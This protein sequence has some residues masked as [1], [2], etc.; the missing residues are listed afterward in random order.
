MQPVIAFVNDDKDSSILQDLFPAVRMARVTPSSPL[1]LSQ[2]DNTGRM[3]WVDPMI[4]GY[5]LVLKGAGTLAK[6][7][8]K[9]RAS[10][11]KDCG[12]DGAEALS[13]DGSS[14]LATLAREALNKCTQHLKP[15]WI[16]VPQLPVVSGPSRNK[17]NRSLAKA[18]G[19]W[20]SS[21]GYSAKLVLP[22]VFTHQSQLKNRTN[23]KPKIATARKCYE[24][25]GAS[26]VW[27]VDASLEDQK[28]T[29][30]FPKR[31][32]ALVDFHRDLRQAFPD[33][34]IVAGPYWG[35]NLV[36]WS[37][38]LCD[39]PAI[40]LGRG[41]R[42]SVSSTFLRAGNARIAITPLLRWAIV[43][44][45][46]RRWLDEVLK[47]LSAQD[48]AYGE[49]SVLRK[50]LQAYTVKGAAARQVA[51]FY[52]QWLDRLSASAPAGRALALYQEFSSAFVLGRQLP[53]MPKA[54]RTARRPERVA[55][56]LML[57]CL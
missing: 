16:T 20:R 25:S 15:K 54:E 53:T 11:E 8:P 5:D 29:G 21:S 56:Q 10:L 31:F 3:L 4:D 48:P 27:A 9:C 1:L 2:L 32:G 47:S 42:Y 45:T 35:M 28:G 38:Q 55:E 26:V 43:S 57:H 33:A 52:S 24:D 40:S 49:L 19:D 18:T 13:G 36:L 7:W 17:V 12:V 44:P 51:G 6:S 50:R 23:W 41:Y 22:L 37:R 30:N 34:M 14:G 46:L 39:C